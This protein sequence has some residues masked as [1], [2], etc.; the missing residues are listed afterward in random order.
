MGKSGLCARAKR[1]RNK[2]R[3]CVRAIVFM[4][5]LLAREADGAA[6]GKTA[7]FAPLFSLRLKAPI[8]TGI[9]LAGTTPYKIR[10]QHTS[11]CS[12]A[13]H[14]NKCFP[15]VAQAPNYGPLS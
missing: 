8:H 2:R 7:N 13:K 5:N 9:I 12:V 14:Q 1:K 10:K 3:A 6:A 15:V 11:Y 4:P